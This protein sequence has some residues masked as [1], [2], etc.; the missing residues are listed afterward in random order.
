MSFARAR[1]LVCVC[2]MCVYYYLFDIC[3]FMYYHNHPLSATSQ[4][5]EEVLPFMNNIRLSYHIWHVKIFVRSR[6]LS[7]SR[8]FSIAHSDRNDAVIS[9]TLFLFSSSHDMHDSVALRFWSAS[10]PP[11]LPRYAWLLL[12]FKAIAPPPQ[13]S[14]SIRHWCL[15]Y[16]HL[17]MLLIWVKVLYIFYYHEHK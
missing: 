17:S 15:V 6:C 8:S 7:L 16:T 12:N 1:V 9:I 2:V 5:N 3:V 10:R 11:S 14:L 4:H 13:I